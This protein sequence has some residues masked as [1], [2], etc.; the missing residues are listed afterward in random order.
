[1]GLAA[2]IGVRGIMLSVEGIKV[3]LQPL[4]SRDTGIDRAA[5]RLCRS[6]LQAEDPFDGL[7]RRPKNLGPFQRVPVIAKATLERLG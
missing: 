5:N 3:L 2:D 7:S 6:G 1:M 4:V